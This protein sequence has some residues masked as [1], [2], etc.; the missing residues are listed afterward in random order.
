MGYNSAEDLVSG[1]QTPQV[2]I[3][4]L[5]EVTS[6]DSKGRAKVTFYG[7]DTEA[8][9]TYNYIDSYVPEIGDKVLMLGQGNTF[10]IVGAVEAEEVI[11]K[12]A[13]K[14]HDHN[15]A[16][17]DKTTFDN[18][19]HYVL[20]RGTKTI[21]LTT[22]GEIVPSAD[23]TYNL[24]TSAKAFGEGYIDNVI[25]TYL[26]INGVELDKEDVMSRLYCPGNINYYLGFKDFDLVPN[27]SKK[28]SLGTNA[29]QYYNVYS[30]NMYLNGSAISSSDKRKKKF[31]RN[32]ADKYLELFKKLRPVTFK[33]K[34]GTSGRA[35]AGF[36]A[37]EVEQAMQECGITNEEFGG[38]VIQDNGEYGLRYEEFIA[39]HTAAIQNLQKKVEELERR[40][41]NDRV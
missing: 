28:I 27:Q 32:L 11:V 24:G 35:H 36:I 19:S 22:D 39:L 4:R 41:S 8:G 21:E 23:A 26:T 37:Q 17:A 38:L 20:K 29:Y 3:A 33:Y 5:A 10:I 7:E 14:T 34:G 9:K 1:S 6:L 40:V 13:L 30:Q 18:H 25:V 2:Q 31:I 12:Y 15:D 16:Y